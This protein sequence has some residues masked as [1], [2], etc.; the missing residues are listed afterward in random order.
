MFSF[1]E[2]LLFTN[3]SAD[4]KLTYSARQRRTDHAASGDD[5]IIDLFIFRSG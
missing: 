1:I 3:N 2:H 5:D 4:K